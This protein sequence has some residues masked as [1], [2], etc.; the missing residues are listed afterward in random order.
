VFNLGTP[1][2]AARGN[3]KAILL[4]GLRGEECLADAKNLASS[5][6][7]YLRNILSD[8]NDDRMQLTKRGEYALRT[9][10]QL[11]VAQ[12]LGREL[13]SVS[14]LAHATAQ[15]RRTS[16]HLFQAQPSPRRSRG[17]FLALLHEDES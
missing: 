13:V 12:E 15:G 3:A 1:K 9:F 17:G 2:R 10:I 8:S 16:F 5:V 14:E 4:N 11:G 7:Y 6:K